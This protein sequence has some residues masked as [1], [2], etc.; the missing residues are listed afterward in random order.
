MEEIALET[1]E[2]H[3]GVSW[4]NSGVKNDKEKYLKR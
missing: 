2:L 3:N 1:S 4:E